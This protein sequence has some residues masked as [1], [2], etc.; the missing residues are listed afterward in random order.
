MNATDEGILLPRLTTV[1][2]NN[3]SAAD[4][5]LVVFDTT[6]NSLQRW[7]GSAW[8][9]MAAGFGKLGLS[10]TSGEY[11]FYST[12]A[13]VI[14]AASSGDT[15][16]LFTDIIET[17]NITVTCVNNVNINF[18]GFTYTLNT[19]GTSNAFTIPTN[20]NVSMFNGRILRTGGTAATTSSVAITATGSG[21]FNANAMVFESD[22]GT[23]GYFL[24]L[25]RKVVGGI[26]DG[27]TYG[28][29]L[30]GAN[31]DNAFLRGGNSSGLYVL[32]NGTATN[33]NAY[34]LSSQG[35]YNNNGNC[36]SSQGRSDGN[37]GILIGN[38]QT[39]DCKGYSTANYGIE[40]TGAP[41][42]SNLFGYSSASSGISLSGKGINIT[43]YST[44]SYGVYFVKGSGNHNFSSIKAYSNSS[45]GMSVRLN[46]G[47]VEF[48][49]V[50][51]A[52]SSNSSTSHGIEVLGNDN[53]II[54]N[55][56]TIRVENASANGLFSDSAKSCYFVG[57]KFINSTTAVNSNITNLQS[58]TPDAFGNILIG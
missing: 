50:N 30:N 7:N 56:G 20:V 54:F 52:T 23:A 48:N 44:A 1:Q 35:I 4:L 53:D 51:S 2:K 57:L 42:V 49:D 33:C 10:N 15:I 25:T 32:N 40:L 21:T 58:N 24:S 36:F 55:G 11:T 3:I 46:G 19:S 37:V 18:N 12:F 14:A 8:V 29:Y 43:G 45:S 34:S 13:D 38:G 9:S 31:L 26:F 47:K 17:T 16:Q 39:F 6:L 27:F 22:F 28:C 41:N 5:N